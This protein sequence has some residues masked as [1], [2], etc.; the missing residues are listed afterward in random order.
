MD[1]RL[2]RLYSDELTHLR[3]V[4]SEFA[5]EFPKIAGRLGMEGT[6]V[7]D[8]YVERLL[9]G[10]AFLSA[11]V[12]LKLDA[13]HPR[14]ISHLLESIYPNFLAPVPSMMVA[15]FTVDVTDP[16]LSKGFPVPRD[17]AL[18]SGLPR[19]QDTR[20]EFRTS[21]DVKLVSAQ[22]FSHATDLPMNRLPG[23]GGYRGGLRL[24]IRTG[25]GLPLRQLRMD[26]L[27]L[28]ISA[29]DD[30]AF[31]LH[32]LVLG[33]S[34]GSYVTGS[35]VDG[36]HALAQWR[37]G[38]SIAP[39]G[40]EPSQALLPDTHR[41]FSGCR[42]LQEAAAM[43]RRFLFFDI[44]DLADRLARVEGQEADLVLF[45]SRA[46]AGLEAMVDVNSLSLHCTPAINLFTKRL[47][48]IQLGPGSWEYHV[49]PD[50]TRPMDFEVHSLQSVIGYGAGQVGQQ[51]FRPLYATYHEPSGEGAGYYTARREPRLL[52]A[53][54][55]EQGPR[56]G[57]IGEELFVSLVDPRH[58]PYREDIRQL[59]VS[60]LVS[61]RDL[62]TLLP[63]NGS[64]GP[65]AWRLDAA[66]PVLR[67]DAVHGP[68]R[69]VSRQP[70]GEAGW[71]LVG[72]LTLQQLPFA[73]EGPAQAAATLRR[74]LALYGPPGDPSWQRLVDGVRQVSV[75]SVVRRL[76][77]N[78][79]LS[80]GCGS[81]IDLE[82]DELAFQGHSAFLFGSVL[83]Y[84]FA[85]HA[86]INS[87]TQLRLR[88]TQRGELRR[89][90][91]RIGGEPVH[92]SG[93]SLA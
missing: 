62:P 20:C 28:Y 78:G 54:Q 80:H 85:R 47:D 50:R 65:A 57:Y 43:P 68:T 9:E 51:T 6:E 77:F 39:V 84:Y 23:A 46:D 63:H 56:T 69:P 41:G 91:V 82:L 70:V 35:G 49:V 71:S 64:A 76:P 59:S 7:A 12:Q 73:D 58:A 45:F 72:L 14:L 32:E 88:T 11:R 79:P 92:R 74:L 5:R 1:P 67:V 25:G 34:V 33:A 10:F 86:A 66:G 21:Q 36:Q 22:Y 89:W 87:F 24:R 60:A 83:E 2:L 55:K 13:E 75:R 31:R 27:Q 15:K 38:T 53:R 48:R 18:Q 19:G 17:S 29:P 30:V 93:G 8:P 3:E 61:N 90:P 26:R 37:D 4:G 52:S 44:T 81:E 42:L 16:N 40:Y